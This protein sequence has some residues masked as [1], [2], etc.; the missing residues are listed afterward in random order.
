MPDVEIGSFIVGY[1]H[2]RRLAEHFSSD[3]QGQTNFIL[4]RNNALTVRRQILISSHSHSACSI[5]V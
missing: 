4:E 2:A 1:V 5:R 3:C